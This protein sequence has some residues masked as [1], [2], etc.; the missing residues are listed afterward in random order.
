MKFYGVGPGIGLVLKHGQ[1]KGRII[2]PTYST[3]HSYKLDYSQSARVI[4][5]DDHGETWQSGEAVNDNR[6]LENGNRIHSEA[7]HDTSEQNTES[8]AVELNSGLVKMFMRNKSG[9]LAVA[10][11]C[12]GG[13]T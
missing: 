13:K 12:D 1:H 6:L 2:F 5:S 11:S 8:V 7:M 3:N 10:T 4:Y 9:K